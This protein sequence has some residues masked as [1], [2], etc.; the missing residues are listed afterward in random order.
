MSKHRC[1]WGV[2]VTHE[3]TDLHHTSVSQLSLWVICSTAMT[4]ETLLSVLP[5]MGHCPW[6]RE[7]SG[8]GTKTV[9][10]GNNGEN[11][12]QAH[13]TG[14]CWWNC[15]FFSFYCAHAA[16]VGD[17]VKTCLVL[18]FL[19]TFLYLLFQHSYESLDQ[20]LHNCWF[21]VHNKALL[22][23]LRILNLC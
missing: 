5:V 3:D 13:R 4:W 22:G 20:A 8:V 11:V 10:G 6:S 21:S 23:V 7:L 19:G 15:V 16:V 18:G 9:R 14:Q 2:D 1:G 17:V 12:A